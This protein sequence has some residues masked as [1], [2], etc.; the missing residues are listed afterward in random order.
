MQSKRKFQTNERV[1]SSFKQI[2]DFYN[3]KKFCPIIFNEVLF[4]LY[5]MNIYQQ[6]KMII[7]AFSRS[8]RCHKRFL[9]CANVAE[10]GVEVCSEILKCLHSGFPKQ[11]TTNSL[12]KDM[13]HFLNFKII[14]TQNQNLNNM[15]GF[16]KRIKFQ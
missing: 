10:A 7:N 6:K 16:F 13:Y 11:N 4:Q 12:Q 8:P 14:K 2:Q 9:T 3:N 5:D 1:S 15:Q